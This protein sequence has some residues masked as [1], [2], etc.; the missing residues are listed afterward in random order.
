MNLYL[1]IDGTLITRDGL[2]APYLKEFLES[3]TAR[4]DC[5]WLT[6]HCRGG[7]NRAE[8]Y[9]RRI[10]PEEYWQYLQYFMPT[11]WN[12]LKTEAIDF[13]KDFRWFDD[14]IFEAEKEVLKKHWCL[15]KFVQIDLVNNPDQLKDLADIL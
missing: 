14:Y 2:P 10:L 13:T 7:E 12:A 3:V 15:N 6:T 5:Y 9:L 1:D 8:E 11:D 4:H